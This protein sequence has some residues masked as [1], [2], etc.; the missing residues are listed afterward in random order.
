MAETLY[1]TNLKSQ[2]WRP[3]NLERAMALGDR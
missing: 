3:V 2:G 1:K